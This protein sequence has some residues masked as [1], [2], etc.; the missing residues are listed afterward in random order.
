MYTT[1]VPMKR[2]QGLVQG[3]EWRVQALTK[4]W[5]GAGTEF[6]EDARTAARLRAFCAALHKVREPAGTRLVTP[7][8]CNHLHVT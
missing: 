5:D 4:E 2:L 6:S 8:L 7:S 3:V 1:H